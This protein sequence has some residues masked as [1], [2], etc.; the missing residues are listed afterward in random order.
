MNEGIDVKS[1][2]WLSRISLRD[3]EA[4]ELMKRIMKARKL[5]DVLLGARLEGVE[6]LYHAVDKEGLLRPDRPS[7]GLGID[8]ALLNAAK[9]EKG[10][11]VAPRTVEEE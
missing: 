11:I 10:F 6:P 7:R 1:L 3:E 2:A 5:I 8:A 4:E 9:R